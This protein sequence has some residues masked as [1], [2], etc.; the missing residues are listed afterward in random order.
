MYDLDE[1]KANF[2]AEKNDLPAVVEREF[3]LSE[4]ITSS[5][6]VE[7]ARAGKSHS[8]WQTIVR[9]FTSFACSAISLTSNKTMLSR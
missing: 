9:T 5:P 8:Y 2:L 3:V 6:R 7:T 4:L 1:F